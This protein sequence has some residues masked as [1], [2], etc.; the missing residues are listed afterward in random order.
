[1]IDLPPLRVARQIGKYN[2]FGL[3]FR[4]FFLLT[5]LWAV[6]G[7]SLWGLWLLGYAQFS[8]HGGMMVWHQHE[9]LVGLGS[10]LAAGFLL[11]AVR[12]WTKLSTPTGW[13][14]AALATT[15]LLGR[16]VWWLDDSI[17]AY[18]ILLLDSLFL[19]WLL[20]AIARPIWRRKQW[21]Q[22]PFIAVLCALIVANTLFHLATITGAV[23]NALASQLATY[24]LVSLLL[25][26]GGRIIP[27]FSERGCALSLKKTPERLVQAY[28]A[29]LLLV[30]LLDM[31][32]MFPSLF[33]VASLLM[34]GLLFA[35]LIYWQSWRT[36]TNPLVWILHL[37]YAGLAIGFLLKSLVLL[38][39]DIAALSTHA[40][41]IIGMG[42][43]G[44]GMMARVS[45][46]HSGRALVVLPGMQWAFLLV[47]TAGVSRLLSTTW[48]V[49]LPLAVVLWIGAFLILLWHYLPVWLLRRVDGQP[50]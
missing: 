48:S 20:W 42:G 46:G 34:F 10:A 23:S 43:I 31:T 26:M 13:M 32:G 30:A 8:P 39:P 15:W 40:W 27:F 45:L 6:I 5:S 18:V 17:P 25:V 24:A 38:R 9:M 11:T 4:P 22:W 33:S 16:L 41:M 49:F 29:L 21:N 14:L 12:N 50:D 36:H 47:I 3:G 7:V 28:F 1:M 19:P 2:L 44:F 37:G 35:Q